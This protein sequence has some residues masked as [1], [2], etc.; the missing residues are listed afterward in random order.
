M[1]R[2]LP[3]IMEW[4]AA[5][6]GEPVIPFSAAFENKIAELPEDEAANYV[7]Q[8]GV[9]SMLV[10]RVHE[11]PPAW[12]HGHMHARPYSR[13]H[14]CALAGSAMMATAALVRAQHTLRAGLRAPALPT[15]LGC[16]VAH[17]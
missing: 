5:N 16:L 4:V 6:G 7:K 13:R 17:G 3:K 10:S 8:A 14:A 1:Y 9:P 15:P 12:T 11:L 2:F